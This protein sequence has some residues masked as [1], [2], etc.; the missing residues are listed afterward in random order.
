M[1]LANIEYFCK[2]CSNA[3]IGFTTKDDPN[4]PCYAEVD[5][6][7]NIGLNLARFCLV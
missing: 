1:E 4:N 2:V 3:G 6:S 7:P 5:F